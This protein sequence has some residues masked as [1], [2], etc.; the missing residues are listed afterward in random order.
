MANDKVNYAHNGPVRYHTILGINRRTRG[1]ESKGF[2][3]TKGCNLT[4]QKKDIRNPFVTY[5]RCF[6]QTG[7]RKKN[8]SELLILLVS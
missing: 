4:S 1:N 5:V 8:V 6:R 2:C 3:H 7:N